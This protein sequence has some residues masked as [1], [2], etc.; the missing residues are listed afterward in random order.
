MVT[1]AFHPNYAGGQM[2]SIHTRPHEFQNTAITS[3]FGFLLEKN[4]VWELNH[5]IIVFK[6]LRFEERFRKAQFS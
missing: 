1:D 5:I 2:S 3:N 4:F 6:F